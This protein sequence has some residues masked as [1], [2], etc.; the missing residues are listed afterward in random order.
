MRERRENRLE[1]VEWSVLIF[2]A[3]GVAAD[4]ALVLQRLG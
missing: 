4:I 2:V 3:V 1:T